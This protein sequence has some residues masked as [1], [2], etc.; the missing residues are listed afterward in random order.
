M[1]TYIGL[2]THGLAMASMGTTGSVRKID[3]WVFP[4]LNYKSDCVISNE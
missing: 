4:T 2:I 3:G 1:G